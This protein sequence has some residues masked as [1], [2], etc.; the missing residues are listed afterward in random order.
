MDEI[1]RDEMLGVFDRKNFD[2]AK[3][4]IGVLAGGGIVVF[5]LGYVFGTLTY[6]ALRLGFRLRPQSWG[7]F[8]EVALSDDA[9]ARV[10]GRLGASRAPDRNYELSA[11]A[12]F[13][14]S[15]LRRSHRG[16]HRWL[17]RRWN[18]FT[19]ATTS[20]CALVIA[21]PFGCLIKNPLMQ[22]FWLGGV[23]LFV[24]MLIFVACWAWRDTMNMVD[25]M[26]TLPPERDP[27]E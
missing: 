11:G 19:I 1:M 7:R 24:V 15:I 13:D 27:K 8:D 9:F 4:L 26:A 5:A 3:L 25:C 17:Y 18:G 21:L 23:I 6:F 12:A 10:W 14:H 2:W 22:R 20:V 16:V